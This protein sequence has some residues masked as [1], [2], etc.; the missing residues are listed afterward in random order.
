MKIRG[1]RKCEGCDKLYKQ[2]MTE[3]PYCGTSDAFSDLLPFDPLHWVYDIEVYPNVFTC[4][5][6]HVQTGTRVNFE[7]SGRINQTIDFSI[8]MTH[9]R[10]AKC[11]MI[12]FNNVGYDYPVVHHMITAGFNIDN[13]FIY[14]QSMR[15]INTPWDDRFQNNIWESEHFVRQIDLFKI[16]HF[17]N[18]GKSTSLKKLEFNMQRANVSD[19]PFPPGT[20]LSSD[21]INTLVE[22]NNEDVDATEDFYIHSLDAIEFREEYN[23]TSINWNDTKIGK[24]YLIDKL[25][26]ELCYVWVN[27]VKLPRQT[28]RPQIRLADVIL[29]YV[30]FEQPEFNRILDYF[31]SQTIT[32]TKGVFNEL[33]ANVKGFNYD[34]GVGGIHG[35]IDSETVIGKIYDWDVKSYYPNIAI[36]N[37]LFPEHLSEEFCK[38]YEE[39]Y[40]DRGKHKKGS[41]INGILKLA[42]NGVYGD[43]NNKYSPFYDPFYTMSITINGQLLLCM[44]AEQLIKIPGLRMI[45]INTDGLTVTC[46][47]EYVDHMNN[48]CKWWE[49]STRLELECGRY[50]RMFIRD[51][52]NYIAEYEDGSLKNKGAYAWKTRLSEGAKWKYDSCIDWHQNHNALIIPHAAEEHLLNGA[53]VSEVIKTHKDINDFMLCTKINRKDKLLF[54]GE[55]I[56]RTTR[57]YVTKTGGKLVKI[58]PPT[59]GYT[60]GQWKRKNKVPDN[61]YAAVMNECGDNWDER[62]HTKNRSKYTQRETK[63]I[64]DRNLTVCNDI[65][66]ANFND[67][68]YDY[69]IQEAHKLINPLERK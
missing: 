65:N 24:N 45:Q 37:K 57:Y 58:S 34:F 26:V 3:C 43:S 41:A 51:V 63:I 32:E 36:A 31:K 68:D 60:V 62:I 19:L 10:N 11:S 9:L 64:G 46:P 35:S 47:D 55:E 38:I 4:S 52:N 2:S 12:G 48:V 50:R 14:E 20:I 67:I 23:A 69:Y 6:K 59:E 30:Q 1:R 66:Q 8:F 39:L 33:S 22:Y 49:E 56:Q 7:I 16:H 61:I 42:L 29:P 40:I 17:D 25:P 28:I 5:F 53:D 15:I 21:Q 27:N 13:D 44:L 18:Q 54:G